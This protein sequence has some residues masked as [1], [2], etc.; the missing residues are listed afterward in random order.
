MTSTNA[1]GTIA[2]PPSVT[3]RSIMDETLSLKQ[4]ESQD[5]GR[6]VLHSMEERASDTSPDVSADFAFALAL[7]LSEQMSAHTI[8]YAKLASTYDQT[9]QVMQPVRRVTERKTPSAVRPKLCA[10]EVEAYVPSQR[11]P[12]RRKK[13]KKTSPEAKRSSYVYVPRIDEDEEDVLEEGIASLFFSPT[14]FFADVCSELPFC[15]SEIN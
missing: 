10:L 1:W 13:P 4:S 12:Q 6:A 15:D 11:Q 8:D 5:Q 2:M 3:L 7:Q 9:L 14:E